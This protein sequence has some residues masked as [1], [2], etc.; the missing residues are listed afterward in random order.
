[1]TRESREAA[2][3]PLDTLA[4]PRRRATAAYRSYFRWRRLSRLVMA[5]C[6][7]VATV[8]VL[9]LVP[10]MPRGLETDDYTPELAFTV[11]LLG[12]VGL[13]GVLALAFS[14]LARREREGLMVWAAVYEETS[15][16]RN[17][18]YLYDRLS[19]ESERARRSGSVFSVIVLQIRLRHSDSV[20]LR[21]LPEDS[22]QKVTELINRDTHPTDLVAKLTDSELAIVALEIDQ[23]SRRGLVER[24]RTTIASELPVY[25]GR[26]ATLDVKGGAAT[27]GVDGTDADTLVQAARTSATLAL[28][29]RAHVA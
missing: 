1:M 25:V 18:T 27:Y 11:Y 26:S 17:R 8:L 15:G 20:P 22:L 14:E 7:V 28:P 12:G 19:L 5:A 24:L 4:A 29:D 2:R 13:T 9:W 21:V 6:L 23:Q 16:L 3:A 10:W